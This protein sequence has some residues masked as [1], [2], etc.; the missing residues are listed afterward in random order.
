MFFVTKKNREEKK[1]ENVDVIEI[2]ENGFEVGCNSKFKY[3][4]QVEIG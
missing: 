2:K 1:D 4:K 3:W